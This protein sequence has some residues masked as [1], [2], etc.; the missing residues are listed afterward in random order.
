[1]KIEYTEQELLEVFVNLLKKYTGMD[2]D[3]VTEEKAFQLMEAVIYCINEY[4]QELLKQQKDLLPTKSNKET[5]DLTAHNHNQYSTQTNEKQTEKQEKIIYNHSQYNTQ[6][7]KKQ[8]EK[9]QDLDAEQIVGAKEAYERGYRLVVE[10]TKKANRL[11]NGI[12][13]EFCD[14]GNQAYYDTMVK[15]MPEFFLRYDARFLPQ[16]ELLWLD[17][18]VQESLEGLCGIDKIE[19]YL[20]CIKIE[21]EYLHSFSEEYI[22]QKCQEYSEDYEELFINL[23]EII[24]GY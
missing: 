21:Q 23:T 20:Y 19:R 16:E 17:Y 24:R 1:M 13:S 9:P 11:Y 6:I 15:A 8:T 18:P 14:Y 2:S 7:H 12:M 22:K 3:S 5:K 4:K 10:K